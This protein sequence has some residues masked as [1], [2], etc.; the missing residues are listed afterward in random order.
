M[1]MDTSL[2]N[3]EVELFDTVTPLTVANF[4]KYVN[5]GDF[6]NSFI[7]RSIPGFIIQGGGFTF[8]NG[9][10]GTVPTDPPVVN[11]F[12]HSNI[13]GTIAMAKISGDPDSATSGWF[14]NLGDNSAN[15]D[16]QNGGFTVFGQVIGNSMEVVDTIAALPVWNAG[17]DFTDL[18]LIDYSGTGDILQ[19]NLVVVNQITVVP[20]PIPLFA[21]VPASH[22][23]FSH[24]ELLAASGITRGCG[25]GNYCPDASVTRAQMVVFLERGMRGSDFNPGSGLGNVFNDVPSGYWAGGWIELLSSDGITT[26]CGINIYCP[27]NAVTREQMAVFLLRA[28]H[29]QDYAPPDA[30]GVFNDVVLSHWSAGW[31]EQL[32]NEGITLGCGNNNYCPKDSVTRAQM[33]VFLVRTFGLDRSLGG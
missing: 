13:R 7:H 2:G 27:E 11:E 20:V 10:I 24:I 1:R 31:I 25:N 33:A 22:W 30:T 14:F 19:D 16:F 15:L 9:A 18:P 3:I 32:A 23:A 21:D 26:G 12:S 5:D 28:K 6:S 8:E 17:G 4:M 29:G